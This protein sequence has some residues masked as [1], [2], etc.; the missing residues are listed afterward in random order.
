LPTVEEKIDFEQFRAA[1]EAEHQPV[2]PT[3]QV[4]VEDIVI[5]RWRLNRIRKMEPGFF[6]MELDERKEAREKYFSPSGPPSSP[7]PSNLPRCLSHRHLRQDVPLR[8]PFRAHFLQSSEGVTETSIPPRHSV[9]FREWDC[10]A[11]PSFTRSRPP[12]SAAW[13]GQ[14]CRLP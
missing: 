6:A 8:S 1:F 11:E 10:F 4:L 9:R 14:S 13:G 5:A 12:K 7:R 3:E 2:G